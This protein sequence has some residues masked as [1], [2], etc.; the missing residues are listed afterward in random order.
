MAI[1]LTLGGLPEREGDLTSGQKSQLQL[2]K[3]KGI[4]T[5]GGD[6]NTE[7]LSRSQ[8]FDYVSGGF[9]LGDNELHKK[10]RS[11]ADAAFSASKGQRSSGML[12]LGGLPER[13]EVAQ[14]TTQ[15]Q[16]VATQDP[17]SNAVDPNQNFIDLLNALGLYSLLGLSGP[18]EMPTASPSFYQ[19]QGML[20]PQGTFGVAP[21]YQGYLPSLITQPGSFAQRNGMLSQLLGM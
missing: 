6:L 5:G 19:P 14:Q 9:G 8:L 1:N 12:T 10:L 2:L 16:N 11:Q 17:L 7:N 3:D 4:V 18:A 21:V 13:T 20:M 15:T